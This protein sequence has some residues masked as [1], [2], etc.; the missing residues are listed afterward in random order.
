MVKKK[1]ILI[2]MRYKLYRVHINENFQ[3]EIRFKLDS[4]PKN[5]KI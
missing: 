3:F 4:I 2:E 5:K 1:S